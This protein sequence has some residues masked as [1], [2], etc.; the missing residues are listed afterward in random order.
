MRAAICYELGQPLVVD[1]VTLDP[2]GPNEVRVRIAATAICH[3]DVHLIRGEWSGIAPI[4][5]GHESAGVVEA[6]GEGVTNLKPG[7]RVVVSLLRSCGQCA[8][9][10]SGAT[11]LCDGSFPIDTESRMHDRQGRALQHG[12][13]RVM[14]F[15]EATIVHESQVVPIPGTVPF[16]TAALLG[17]GVVTGIGAVLNTARVKPGDKV[18]VI[19]AGGVGLNT[20]QGAALA[21]ASS[22]IAIDRLDSKLEAALAFGAT[23]ALNGATMDRKAARGADF[24]FVTVG[25]PEAVTQA[26][27]LI[28]RGGTVVVVGMPAVRATA[29]VR[30]FDLV[31]SEQRLVGSR[32]GGTNLATD[33]RKYADLYL[34]GRLK[35]DELITERFPLAGIND[36]IA[37]MER[38]EALRN[39]IVF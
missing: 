19:G 12:G 37:S 33:V 22:I 8:A 4:V 27:T 5:A 26:L 9:C 3:S 24:V 34:D 21:E 38:G 39:V 28:R 11:H 7:D 30:V 1:E 2:P 29:A 20:I 13:I 32:M 25:S 35:L 15:A 10:R 17:C 31:W 23:Q 36:A 18:V 6:T 14:S 16:D